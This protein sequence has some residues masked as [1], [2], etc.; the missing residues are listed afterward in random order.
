MQIIRDDS[1][2]GMPTPCVSMIPLLV[3][4]KIKRCNIE[5][6]Q[7][8]P[9]TIVA[10]VKDAPVFGLCESHFSEFTKEDKAVKIVLEFD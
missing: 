3:Q 7:N 5:H 4:W 10:G 8:S 1:Q 2:D 6:C 9:T